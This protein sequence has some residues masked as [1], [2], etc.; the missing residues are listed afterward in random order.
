MRPK[1]DEYR[2]PSIGLALSGGVARGVAHIGVLKVLLGNGIPIDY[3]AGTSAGALVGA[4]LAAGTSIEKLV[5]ISRSLRWKNVGRTTLSRLGLQSNVRLEEFLRSRLPITRFEDLKI[6]FA[7]VATDLHSGS[8]VIMS[9]E[10]D[11]PFAVR[12]SCALP[13]WFVP[14]ID[15][16]GRH[17]I[18]GGLVANIPTGVVRSLGADLVIAVDVNSEGAKFLGPPSSAFGILFQSIM[19]VQRTAASHQLE[20]ADLVI[21]PRLGHI[22]WDELSRV[23]EFIAAGEEA[24]HSTLPRIRQLIEAAVE[25]PA[26]WYQIRRRPN[27]SHPQ[28]QRRRYSP[29]S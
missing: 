12:A 18:D 5:E 10:G 8:A 1:Q 3:V 11:V 13:G 14:V 22:R 28:L 19:T 25:T 9:G 29:L 21:R 4:G 26:K 27:R 16:R 20:D 6:P 15:D 23:E 17:L 2:R 7:A 24:A